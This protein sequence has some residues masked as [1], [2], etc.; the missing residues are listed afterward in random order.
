MARIVYGVSGEG[1][2]HSSRAREI[3]SHLEEQGHTVKVVSY[4]RGYNN[5]KDTFDVFETE[6]LH[7]ASTNNR[8]SVVETFTNNL[9]RLPAGHKK[10]QKLRKEVFKRFLPDCVFT[11]FEPMTAYLA[12][13]YNLP[14]ISLD[15]QHRMRYMKY[16]C[17]SRFKMDRI[18]TENIIRSMVPKPDISLVTSFYAGETKNDRTFIFPPILRTE[19]RSLESTRREHILVYLT[20]GFESFL[21]KLRSFKRERFLVYGYDRDGKEDNISFMPFSKDGFL[22]DLA[23]CKAVMA[24]AGFTL[25]T[26]ALYLHKPYLALP[27]KGQFEQE[28]N[29]FLLERQNYG[30]NIRRISERA[31]SSFLYHIPDFIQ[32]LKGYQAADNSAIKTKIDE[33]LEENC[34]VAIDFHRKRMG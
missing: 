19:V 25:M 33:I 9:Q 8:V 3:I 10:L 13:H 1:S 23:T 12:N 7:I 11:D 31:I 27:M 22:K 14:L 20:S 24:T 16:P 4:D 29:A 32:H 2:G 21:E 26:E 30:A 6:G 5:L 15:N 18:V 28:L 17:P 34:A